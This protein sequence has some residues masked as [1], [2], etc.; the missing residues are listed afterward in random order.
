MGFGERLKHAW[1]AFS[2]KDKAYMP[3][4]GGSYGSTSPYHRSASGFYGKTSFM[5]SIFNKISMD[6]ATT[7][8]QHVKVD[9][10]EDQEIIYSGLHECLTVEANKDQTAVA[11][12]Q[13]LVYSLFDEG[14]VAVVPVDTSINPKVTGGYDI[15]SLRVGRVTEWFPDHVR[16]N[17]Y[18][19]K[20]GRKYDVLLPKKTVA[21][22]ENPLYAIVNGRNATLTRLIQKINQVDSFDEY[23]ATGRMDI[24][25]QLPYAIKSERQQ[26]QAEARISRLDDMLAKGRHGVGY[27]DA[28]EKIT[29]LNRPANDQL[30][31][32]V[33]TLTMEVYNQLGLTESVF[34]GTASEG[35]LNQYYS[36]TID[37]II[38]FITGE[39]NRKFLTKTARSQGQ[40][41]VTYRD[42]FTFTS[43]EQIVNL[44]D[45][46]RR[47]GFL[48]ANEVRRLIGFKPS[49]DPRADELFNPNIADKNQQSHGSLTPPAVEEEIS[50]NDEANE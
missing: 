7:A 44:G 12:I 6:I 16:V 42:M 23:V 18:N 43:V 24:I 49:N 41:I 48:T 45:T 40:K 33:E 5:S 2:E 46:A 19:D 13:D 39:F 11:F 35:E 38:E 22:I 20:D 9:E 8:F 14:V 34:R 36:R 26:Q 27:I 37:P 1:N 32:E 30:K 21:I 10:K 15:K 31:E 28:I 4:K 47:N 25:L 29:Q 17:L 50:S 3:M